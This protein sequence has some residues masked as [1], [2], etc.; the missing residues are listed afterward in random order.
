MVLRKNVGLDSATRTKGLL[1]KENEPLRRTLETVVDCVATV[2]GNNCEVVL[3]SFEDLGHTVTK[4]A[5]GHVTR[6]KV[7]SPMTDFGLEIISKADTLGKDVVGSYYTQLD[8]GRQLK[9]ASMLVRDSRGKLIGMLCINMDLSVPL[10]DFAKQMV[11]DE[12]R[13][14]GQPVEHFPTSLD[15]LM[16]KTFEAVMSRVTN[17]RKV[18]PAGK[19]KANKAVVEELY[20]RGIASGGG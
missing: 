18:S 17:P 14:A 5:N 13:L 8:D 20:Q 9:S 11:Q 12:T 19:N 3:H 16:E 6:R 10:W 1:D 15:D 2:F 7:G 4:I